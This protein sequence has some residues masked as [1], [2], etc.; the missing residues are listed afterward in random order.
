MT[1]NSLLTN[2]QFGFRTKRST[3]LAATLFTDDIRHHVDNKMLVGCIFIDFSKAFDTLSHAKLLQ[4]LPAYGINQ[5][6]LEWFSS[7]LFNRR[8]VIAYN[9]HSSQPGHVITGVPQGSILGPLLFLIYVNDIVDHIKQSQIINYADDTVLYTP[10][11]DVVIIEEKLSTDMQAIATWCMENELILNLKKGKTESMLFGT[12]KCLS[13]ITKTLEIKYEQNYINVTTS[14]KYLGIEID[15][16]LSMSKHF[17]RS[18]KK[19]SGR[20]F[21]LSKLRHQLNVV[22]AAAIFNTMVIP[23]V[24]YCCL[25]SLHV[26]RTQQSRLTS[27]DNRAKKIVDIGRTSTVNLVSIEGFKNRHACKFVKKC[28]D[29]MVCENFHEY[30]TTISHGK[31]TRNNNYLLKL[32]LCRTEFA[33]KSVSFMAANIYNRLPLDIRQTDS[34][35][36]F[37]GKVNCFFD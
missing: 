31:N 21:L 3:E 25:L 35:N 29:K 8:Q 17:D 4:K 7:Y 27:L 5:L 32:P 22:S 12:S 16:T 9:N 30:F 19:A 1:E 14:Y 6:E 18:Y 23:I 2:Q 34:Y 36:I 33:R 28:M 13:S 24:T 20:L 15:A 37:S 10:G 26:T 11:K